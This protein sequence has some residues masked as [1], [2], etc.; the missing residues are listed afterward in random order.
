MTTPD[1]PAHFARLPLDDGSPVAELVERYRAG[2]QVLRA[3]LAGLDADALRERPVPGKWSSLEALGHIA[4]ADQFL[5]DRMKR[6]VAV[7][8]PLLVGVDG[9]P[10]LEAL[11][12]Q[13]RDPELLLTM[14]DVVRA[15]TSADLERLPDDAWEHAGVHTEVGL[16]TLR[17]QLLHAITHLEGHA[18][19]IAEKRRALGLER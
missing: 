13:D 6:T 2:S 18:E 5:A 14:I 1:V 19:A 12:Y 11:S 9:T 15:Q 17:Q 3:V 4:D 10:Y 8:V 16:I 7:A